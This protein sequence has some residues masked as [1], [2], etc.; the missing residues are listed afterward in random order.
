MVREI[1]MR[2]TTSVQQQ[3]GGGRGA[4][5]LPWWRVA[6]RSVIA[7]YRD[8][9]RSVIAPYRWW[10]AFLAMVVAP[11]ALAYQVSVGTY[12][13]NA[14]RQITVPVALD[15]AAGLSYASA[16]ITYDP[17][18]LVVTKAEAG[19]LKSLMAEDFVAVDTNGTLTVSI[20]GSTDANVASGSGSIANVTFAVREGTAGLYSDLAVSSV[21][22]GEKSGVKDVTAGNPVQTVSGMVRVMG[23]TAEVA[24][25]ENAEIV[26]ADTVLGALSLSAGDAIQ[27]SDAQTAIRVSGA[28]SASGAIVV[29]A[30]ANGWA[31]GT[32][33]LLSTTT[34]GLAF[35]LEGVSGATFSSETANGVTTYYAVVSIV[36]KIITIIDG[37]NGAANLLIVGMPY[38]DVLPEKPTEGRTGY[39]FAGWRTGQNG[40]GRL[41]TS[42]S[43]VEAGDSCIYASWSANKYDVV[44]HSN[45][46]DGTM[47]NQTNTYDVV[48]SLVSNA[49]TRTSHRFLGWATNETSEVVYENGAVVSNM[50]TVAGGLVNLYAVWEAITMKVEFDLNYADATERVLPIVVTNG[51]AYGVLPV[52]ER[53][54]YVFDGWANGRAIDA[55]K[56]SAETVVTTAMDHTL[57]AQWVPNFYTVTFE[58]N[59]GDGG[60][61]RNMVYCG[62]IISPTVTR[63]GYTFAGWSPEVDETVPASNVMYTAQWT[64]NQYELTF[65]VN[66]GVYEGG[67]MSVDYDSAYGELPTPTR[68]GYTFTGWMAD[69]KSVTPETVMGA[70][71]VSLVAQWQI[72][73]YTVA[74]DANGGVGSV[75]NQLDYASAI[76]APTVTRTG[77]TFAGWSPEVDETVPASNVM[78]TAQW[79]VNQYELTF[80]VNGGVYEGGDMSV[81]FDSAYGELPTPTREGY[82]FT[83]WMADGVVVTPESVMGAADVSLVAQWTVN[84]YTV[85]FDANGGK[86]GATN[87]LDYASEIVPPTVTR[88]G[89]TFAGWSPEVV[90]TVPASNVTYTA[91]WT[92]NA[93]A[94]TFNA[95]GGTGAMAAQTFTNDVAQSLSENAF[96]RFGYEFVGWATSKDGEV[97]YADGEEIRAHSGTTLYA[98]WEEVVAGKLNTS[99][100]KAQTVD[101]ALY[102]GDA[103]VGTMQVKV[104]KK[105]KKGVVKVSASATMLINGKAKKVT[106]KAVNVALD[107]MG[108]VAPVTIAFKK[109]IGNM[110]FEMETD[111]TFTLKNGSY[112]MAEA[113]IGGA[114]KGR[115]SKTFSIE[116]FKLKVQGRLLDELLPMDE[117]FSV[118]SGKWK[119]AKA[120]MV[121]WAKPNK[122][123]ALSE[124]YNKYSGKDLIIDTSK[125]KTNLSGLK[126]TY[127]SKTGQFKGSFKVYVLQGSGKKMKLAKYTVNVIGFVVDGVG[128]G[129]ALCKKPATSWTVTV[130]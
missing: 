60:W 21:E 79:T 116:D 11:V 29:K 38:G 94:V 45:G 15:S 22:L 27:A 109:P 30:P 128:Y 70:A 53:E 17:Q 42:E 93:Y 52:V 76:V 89:Y 110:T 126:L 2:N 58:A 4:T 3:V 62:S 61:S 6:A 86:G 13:A 57:Y 103:L 46:G 74:F 81:D 68:E 16:T 84:K 73:Q 117:T 120:A 98:K 118:S 41:V 99:F 85:A 59:G 123:A 20:F 14:G 1:E 19:S 49:F 43:L 8:A 112:L 44:F 65:D 35:S 115:A 50:T 87:E 122:G 90:A 51:V 96:A 101:G 39:S 33:A 23:E 75:T 64:V 66:G 54:G 40:T 119:F 32:Y 71:D 34:A 55:M 67:D 83:G 72:N 47:P 48:S 36:S 111:G 107:A 124:Y 82:S 106:A 92:A 121:K 104:G 69:G 7:P 102:K 95:N 10:V 125:G 127:T 105:N 78:Y 100:A 24:R 37:D 129:Q 31:S 63:T 108:R 18:V 28:V 130:E 91:R 97:V 9:A 12:V 113:K 26:V 80:D 114:L 25:L 77:Y 5:A 88:T 56:V